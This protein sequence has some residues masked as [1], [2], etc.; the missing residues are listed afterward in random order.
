ML[1]TTRIPR[2]Q[3][4]AGDLVFFVSGGRA[5]HVGIVVNGTTMMDAPHH[6][7]TFGEHPIFSANVVFGRVS[8]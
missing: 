6:G 1:A 8:A 5:Y 3:A 4:R 7:T 2:D